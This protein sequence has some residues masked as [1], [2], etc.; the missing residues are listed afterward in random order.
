MVGNFKIKK[1]LSNNK[2]IKVQSVEGHN[3]NSGKIVIKAR[4]PKLTSP[5]LTIRVH[6][7]KD[8]FSTTLRLGTPSYIST[9]A[10]S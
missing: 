5:M 4:E 2:H 6:E 7:P 8:Q 3:S 1:E 9:K 10:S